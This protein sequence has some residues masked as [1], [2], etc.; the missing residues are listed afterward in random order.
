MYILIVPSFQCDGFFLQHVDLKRGG[1][2]KEEEQKNLDLVHFMN[3]NL[4]DRR[5]KSGYTSFFLH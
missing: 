4:D 5:T 2:Q 1:A 3:M